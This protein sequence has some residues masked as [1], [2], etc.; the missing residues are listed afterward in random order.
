MHLARLFLLLILFIN[1]DDGKAS[2]SGVKSAQRLL[3]QIQEQSSPS[4]TFSICDGP[5]ISAEEY[6]SAA[7][8]TVSLRDDVKKKAS[9]IRDLVF[10]FTDV[11]LT[12]IWQELFIGIANCDDSITISDLDLFHGHLFRLSHEQPELLIVFHAKE[13]PIEIPNPEG[14]HGGFSTE[15]SE[16]QR[17]NILYLSS[18]AKIYILHGNTSSFW[19]SLIIPEGIEEVELRDIFRQ[20]NTL[21]TEHFST[22]TETLGDVNYFPSHSPQL[23]FTEP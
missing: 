22:F 1:P 17:R 15:S 9:G 3:S 8:V 18:T 12:K 16:Y 14:K 6:L 7:K 19:Q 11:N 5:V 23:F 20:A 2:F 4:I 21:Q 10:S 13:Y